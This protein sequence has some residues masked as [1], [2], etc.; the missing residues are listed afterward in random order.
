MCRRLLIAAMAGACAAG[1]CSGLRFLGY[2]VA[3]DGPTKTVQAEF[4]GLPGS[5]LAVVIYTDESIDCDYPG[6]RLEVSLVLAEEL[7]RKIPKV[8]VVEPRSIIKYQDTNIYWDAMD[9]TGLGKLFDARYVLL[10]SLMEF[11]T[12]EPGS[13]N[14]YRGRVV[15]EASLYDVSRPEPQARV[16][17]CDSLRVLFPPEATTGQLGRSDRDI[18]YQTERLFAEMLVGKFYKHKVPSA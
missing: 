9:K 7:R 12:R 14:L 13:M 3:P 10:V 17:H 8:H 1:G 15:A 11:S 16:W 2:V 5:R 4:D 6:T 18:R